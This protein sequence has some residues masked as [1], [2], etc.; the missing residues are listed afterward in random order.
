MLGSCSVRLRPARL[1]TSLDYASD[2]DV[3]EVMYTSLHAQAAARMMQE[4]R[5]TAAAT[6]R[7]R[8]SFLF[9]YADRMGELLTNSRR[10]TE[11]SANAGDSAD[12]SAPALLD[13][14]LR[15]ET[16]AKESFG[17]VRAAALRR[18]P[19]QW[20]ASRSRRRRSSRRRPGPPGGAACDRSR[21]MDVDRATVYAAELA[22]FDGTDL[23]EVIGFERVASR[24]A[25]VIEGS[26]WPGPVTAVRLARSDARS[27]STRCACVIDRCEHRHPACWP[28]DDGGHRRPRAGACARRRRRRAWS[29]LSDRLP[30]CDRGRHQRRAHRPTTL[31]ACR[32]TRRSLR[33]RRPLDR[34][35]PMARS[36]LVDDRRDRSLNRPAVV[37]RWLTSMGRQS[38]M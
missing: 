11:A 1:P 2:V 21:L 35:A 36:S 31:S 9:G 22:A 6:Q 20:L 3:V 32:P 29:L 16:F 38:G 27:S 34:D 30:R 33:R 4:R 5:S 13:R 19:G 10:E 12:G 17:R 37:R 8:R 18:G 25:S 28:S 24:L 23:E 26:W 7:F 14:R 15:V